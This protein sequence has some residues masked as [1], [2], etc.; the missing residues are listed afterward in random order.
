MEVDVARVQERARRAYRVLRRNGA[1]GFLMIGTALGMFLG[2]ALDRG[3]WIYVAILA[4][5]ILT[6]WLA[7]R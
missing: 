7:A 6:I 3:R 4:L 5:A 2:L 1:R